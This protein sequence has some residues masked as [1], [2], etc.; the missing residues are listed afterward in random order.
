MT[1]GSFTL[2]RSRAERSKDHNK[3]TAV[4]TKLYNVATLHKAL[5]YFT[6]H[7]LNR[8]ENEALLRSATLKCERAF[9]IA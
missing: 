2:E 5:I 6:E 8:N 7:T 9:N 1:K 3:A 4:I